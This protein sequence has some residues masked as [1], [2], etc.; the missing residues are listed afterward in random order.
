MSTPSSIVVR[1]STF[2]PA[3]RCLV[4]GDHI[5]AGEG[6]TAR[7]G[8]ETLRFKCHGCLDR[9]REAPDRLWGGSPQTCC[10]DEVHAEAPVSEWICD[11]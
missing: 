1:N 11:R 8:N 4:C 2:E 9:F 5:S 10:S 6:L 7:Y 3:A